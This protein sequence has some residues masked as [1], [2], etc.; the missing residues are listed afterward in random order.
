VTDPLREMLADR[1]AL[2]ADG[3]MGTGLFA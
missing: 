1:P 3:G 2:L